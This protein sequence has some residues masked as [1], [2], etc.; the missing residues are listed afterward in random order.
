LA[1]LLFHPAGVIPIL[2]TQ[3]LSRI[4]Q[5]AQAFDVELDRQTWYEIL[6]ASQ[7]EPLP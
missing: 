4:T 6:V 5:S 7:G 1:W 3:T 2:G